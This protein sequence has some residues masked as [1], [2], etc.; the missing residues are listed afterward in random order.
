MQASG[1]RIFFCM[2]I[3]SEDDYE[4]ALAPWI[5]KGLVTLINWPVAVGQLPA[6]RDCIKRARHTCKWVAFLDIDEFLFA[7]HTRS[8]LSVLRDY[9]DLPGVEV[10]QL[11]FGSNGHASPPN[12]PVTEAYTMRGTS[13]RTT[14][15]TIVNPRLVYKVGVHQFKFWHGQALDVA[16]GRVA[17]R[18][19]ASIFAVENQPL[20]VAVHR[21]FEDEDCAWRCVNGRSART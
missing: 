7:P 3:F 21:G 17:P 15:K 11:F 16:R 18:H 13:D 19:D 9:S 10:W 14:V 2:T 1:Q 20:L 5:G 4:R 8:I 6:Y 12:V